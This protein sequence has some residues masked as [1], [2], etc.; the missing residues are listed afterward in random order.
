[1][2]ERLEISGVHMEVGDKLKKYVENKIGRCDRF[3]PRQHRADLHAEVKLKQIKAK[4]KK[5][6]I[7]EVVAQLPHETIRIE[8][9]TINIYAAVDIVENKLENQFK[10]YKQTHGDPKIYRR[11]GAKFK[12]SRF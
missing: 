4:D 5:H 12:N 11:L 10:K 9:S 7:C 6:C 1:M 2:V 3:L 8:E